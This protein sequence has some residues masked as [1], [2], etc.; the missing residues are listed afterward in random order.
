MSLTSLWRVAPTKTSGT[1]MKS[2]RNP[3]SCRPIPLGSLRRMVSFG[4]RFGS[5]NPS[6]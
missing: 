5:H 2:F 1:V 6:P 3:N 4:G